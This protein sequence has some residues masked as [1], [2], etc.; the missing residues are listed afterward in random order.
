MISRQ[1]AMELSE[2]LVCL[3]GGLDIFPT[4]AAAKAAQKAPIWG[5]LV[6]AL[7]QTN[8]R[9]SGEDLPERPPNASRHIC[10][11]KRP[12]PTLEGAAREIDVQE[13]RMRHLSSAFS[14][15]GSSLEP[16]GALQMPIPQLGNIDE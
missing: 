10:L 1:D 8:R 2:N 14:F 3:R 16:T 5:R 12:P 15:G 11:A 6:G 13:N 7:C 4:S 9:N